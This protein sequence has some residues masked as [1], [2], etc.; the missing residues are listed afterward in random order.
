[1]EQSTAEIILAEIATLPTEER[2]KLIALLNRQS[3]TANNEPGQS[4]FIP[5]F[6][7]N[8]PA[9]SL[10]WIEEHYAEFAGQYVALDGDHLVAHSADPREVIAIVR[11]SG[12]KGLFFTRIPPADEPPFAGF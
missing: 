7:T 12:Q 5:P 10:S 2:E 11:G 6:D 4:V 9:P 1:M 3:S 8:D